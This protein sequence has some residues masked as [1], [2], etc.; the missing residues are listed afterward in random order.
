MYNIEDNLDFYKMLYETQDSI[1]TETDRCL[2]TNEELSENY[3]KLDCNHKFN[4]KP[5]FKDIYTRMY[6]SHIKQ[7]RTFV[8]STFEPII[9]PYCRGENSELLPYIPEEYEIKIY[10]INT[11]EEEYKIYDKCRPLYQL[12]K[13]SVNDCKKCC[14]SVYKL[15]LCKAHGMDKKVLKS[16]KDAMKSL[17]V[18]TDKK[19]T[20]LLQKGKRKGEECNNKCDANDGLC[21]RHK[22]ICVK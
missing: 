10:G 15:P 13:C 19:C 7:I 12:K 1:E 8:L 11:L 5:I 17:T 9:C 22:K 20:F 16:Y 14:Y 3:I 2:I 18:K 6:M 21:K 4:Y